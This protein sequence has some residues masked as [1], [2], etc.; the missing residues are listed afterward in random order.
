[1]TLGLDWVIAPSV[2]LGL[3]Y[4]FLGTTSASF[5]PDDLIEGEG[6]YNQQVLASL[7]IRF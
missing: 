4:R 3:A 1:V 7:T 2:D 5:G 6:V